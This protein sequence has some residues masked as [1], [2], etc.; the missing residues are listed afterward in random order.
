MGSLWVTLESLWALWVDFGVSLHHSGITLEDFGPILAPCGGHFGHFWP[1]LG[2]LLGV[3]GWLLSYFRPLSENTH[4]S[5]ENQWFCAL[6]FSIWAAW[7]TTLILLWCPLQIV[8]GQFVVT[9][10]NFGSHCSLFGHMRATWV[11][12]QS[13]L[14]SP[15]AHYG[16]MKAALKS[17]RHVLRSLGD[18]LLSISGR[19][20]T[21]WTHFGIT[22]GVWRLLWC[23]FRP[24][25]E[26]THFPNE[27]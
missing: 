2:S 24:F 23:C 4:F 26:N 14:A 8:W 18:T 6:I 7:D 27:F 3:W 16:H 12:F 17:P 10:G 20:G 5:N 25:A 19:F 22:L 21:P 9:L 13:T 15:W 1:A 11:L